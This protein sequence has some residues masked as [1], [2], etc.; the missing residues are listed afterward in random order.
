MTEAKTC[1]I[2]GNSFTKPSRVSY[3]LWEKRRYCSQICSRAAQ[4]G[5]TTWTKDLKDQIPPRGVPCRICGEPTRYYA[6]RFIGMVHCAKPECVEASRAIK[7]QRLAENA[8]IAFDAGTRQ[9][10]GQGWKPVPLVSKD[11]TALTPWFESIGWVAQFKV[12]TGVHSFRLPRQFKL[13]FA[14]PEKMLF[15]EIDGSSHR[16]PDRKER[17]A[18]RDAMLAELGWRGLRIPASSVRDLQS[19][20]VTISTWLDC[21]SS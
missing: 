2:C 9:A 6:K 10:A 11:E 16:T 20:Q 5:Q 18:R 19:A 21:L 13:D 7:N 17:D 4:L 12:N 14:L 3:S 15:V 8:R 1:E